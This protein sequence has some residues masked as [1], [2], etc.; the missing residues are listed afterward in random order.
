MM[1]QLKKSNLITLFAKACE[2]EI[3]YFSTRKLHVKFFDNT[4]IIYNDN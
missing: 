1:T 4:A 3:S 2:N